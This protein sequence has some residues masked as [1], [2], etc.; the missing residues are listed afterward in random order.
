MRFWFPKKSA[1]FSPDFC[2]KYRDYLFNIALR[3]TG[4]KFYAEDVVQDTICKLIQSAPK[5]A[6]PTE[7][8]LKKYITRA[9]IN[10]ALTYMKKILREVPSE[11]LP[12][13]CSVD[14]VLDEVLAAETHEQ[15]RAALAK[16]IER[17][18]LVLT[19]MF[20]ENWS[21]EQIAE[22]MNISTGGVRML[23][24]RGL[25]TMREFLLKEGWNK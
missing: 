23:K 8:E 2:E 9:V 3:I 1:V 10:N 25:E 15:I 16:L 14:A 17:Q 21:T 6:K 18:R 20:Y 12:E 24:K 19:L 4:D 13:D 7:E 22:K 5:L 11:N